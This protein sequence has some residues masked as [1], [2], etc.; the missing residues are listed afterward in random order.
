MCAANDH[1]K[2][3]LLLSVLRNKC[4]RCRR[5]DMFTYRNPYELKRMMKMPET[6]PVCGQPL[7]IEVGFY[8]GTGFVSYA[9][10]VAVSVASFIAWKVIIGMSLEDSRLF[11]WLGV[12]ALLLLGLQPMLMRLSRVIWIYFFVYYDPNW[13]EVPAGAPERTNEEMKNNW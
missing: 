3:G 11:W 9:L 1:Y 13:S 10:A 2:P 4:P 8:Y 6:C 12:N 5:G 7:E